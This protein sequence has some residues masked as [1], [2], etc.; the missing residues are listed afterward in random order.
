MENQTNK[1]QVIEII[2]NWAKAVR[3]KNIEGVLA[4]HSANIL[5]FDVPEPLQSKGIDNYRKS[6]VEQFF[7][8]YGDDGQFELNELEV[9]AGED[10]A[11][12]TSIVNCS[13]KQNEHKVRYKIRLTICLKK[14]NGQW[15]IQHE[16]HSEA[17][18]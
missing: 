9:T 4:S 1:S 14:I 8:W 16:H 12:C 15:V 3:E 2:G 5:L 17:S 18:K 11:F 10:L 6:W 13:G 7:P